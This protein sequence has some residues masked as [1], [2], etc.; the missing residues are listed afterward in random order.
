MEF[1]EVVKARYATKEFSNRKVSENLMNELKEII[2]LSASSSNVQPWRI[3]IVSDSKTKELLRPVSMDQKQ[4]TTCS[5]LLVFLADIALNKR[6]DSLEKLMVKS[7]SLPAS[8]K[9]FNDNSRNAFGNLNT[10]RKI[11]WA[12]KQTYIAL[13]NAI[14]GAKSLGFDSCPMEGF[15]PK[16][17]HRILKL[18]NNLIPTALVTVGYAVDKQRSKIRFSGKDV[19]I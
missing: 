10:T 7:G 15:S 19:F 11:S 9:S 3:K 6:I 13:S 2:R 8:A 16:D 18:P 1:K 5:H 12:S 17:Y 14:N 4:I